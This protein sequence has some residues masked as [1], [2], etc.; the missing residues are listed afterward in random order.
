[1]ADTEIQMTKHLS[2]TRFGPV[3]ENEISICASFAKNE[4]GELICTLSVDYDYCDRSNYLADKS[5]CAEFEFTVPCE[6]SKFKKPEFKLTLVSVC[7]AVMAQVKFGVDY[8]QLNADAIP[9]GALTTIILDIL[10]NDDS[11]GLYQVL[12]ELHKKS[13]YPLRCKHTGYRTK[14]CVY[15]YTGSVEKVQ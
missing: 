8:N 5:A 4:S 15:V 3:T 13:Q 2:D 9:V 14:H 11:I 1:M 6:V 10:G 7:D 12:L